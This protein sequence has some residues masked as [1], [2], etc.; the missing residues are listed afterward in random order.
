[1][2]QEWKEMY[3][4]WA[5]VTGASSGLGAATAVALGRLGWTVALGAR[6]VERM[7]EVADRVREAG[8]DA[9][10][11]A[12]DVADAAS[13]DAFFDALEA[14][15]GI[16]NVVVNNAGA[17]TPGFLFELA[18]EVLAAEVATNLIGPLY[19]C[20]R[21][22]PP[23]L[24]AK[25]RGDL[26]F[27]SSDAVRDYR[28]KQ[29]TY[30]ATKAA[31]EHIARTLVKELEG[32]G[33]R[34]TTVRVGPAQSEFGASWQPEDLGPLLAYWQRYGL[35]RHFSILPSESVAQAI[36]TVVTSPPGVHLDTVEVQPEFPLSEPSL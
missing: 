14:G 15:P 5:V 18:A 19:V 6:R 22:I 32:T 30:G 8:G 29:A 16:A 9:F 36:V 27:V 28:P 1:M 2:K 11:H 26:V 33:I 3:G 35:Q 4:P 17:S 12:L 23:L 20:R 10:V 25:R 13:V 21:A 24:A 34:S 31:L 7:D